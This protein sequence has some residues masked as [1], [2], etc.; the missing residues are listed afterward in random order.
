VLSSSCSAVS[1]GGVLPDRMEG[2]A[3]PGMSIA[4]AIGS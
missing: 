3:E 4:D 2:L 1:T